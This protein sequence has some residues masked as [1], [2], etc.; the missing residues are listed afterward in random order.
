VS[1]PNS[2]RTTSASPSLF[3][4]I[5]EAAAN[6]QVDPAALRT[7]AENDPSNGQLE[8]APPSG[9]PEFLTADE[10]AALLRVNRKTVYDALT[11]NQIPGA[12]RIRT[13]YRI[14]RDA[15]LR[16]FASGQD[17]VSRSRRKR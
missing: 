7:R 14:S 4:D 8:P 1:S 5:D 12:R 17:G 13:A 15:V 11:R 10:L 2:A 6:S 16:W 9:P 3:G